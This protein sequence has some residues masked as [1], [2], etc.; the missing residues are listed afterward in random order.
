M[1]SAAGRTPLRGA[2]LCTEAKRIPLPGWAAWLSELGAWAGELALEGI[3]G[4]IALSVPAR[5]YASVLVGCGAVYATFQPQLNASSG[6]SQFHNVAKLAT[7]HYAVRLISVQDSRAFVGILNHAVS[8]RNRDGYNVGGVWFPADR[9]RIDVLR[10]PDAPGDFM[11]RHPIP[12]EV[13]VPDGA[14]GLLP[15]AAADFY[16]FSSLQCVIVCSGSAVQQECEALVASSETTRLLP[17]SDL[18]R[19]R[20]VRN[21]ARQFRSVLLS[22]WEDPDSYRQLVVSRKPKVAILDGAASV[23]RWFGAGLAPLTVG[24]VERTAPSAETAAD[25][26]YRYRAR[27]LR[28]LP[29]PEDLARVPAGIEVLAWQSGTGSA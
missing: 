12:Q 18:L 2:L 20:T 25:V 29:L 1:E 15:G 10:W 19:P 6:G 16:G 21:T 24:L 9:Y 17:L 28:D 13:I 3:R 23:S 27:S 11:G 8:K 26:L 7:R 4:A 22:A 14:T 5:E